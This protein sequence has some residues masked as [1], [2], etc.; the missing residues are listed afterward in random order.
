MN[1]GG[2]LKTGRAAFGEPLEP[3]MSRRMVE[4]RFEWRNS[5]GLNRVGDIVGW[6]MQVDESM[7]ELTELVTR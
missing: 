5:C 6:Q 7:E 4:D 2:R 3:N 1:R